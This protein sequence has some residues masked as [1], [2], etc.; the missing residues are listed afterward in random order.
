[1]ADLG[2]LGGADI[3]Y[4]RG[5]VNEGHL[6]HD[7]PLTEDVHDQ[8]RLLTR[9]HDLEASLDDKIDITAIGPPPNQVVARVQHDDP[10]LRDESVPVCG[11]EKRD[12]LHGWDRSAAF[13]HNPESLVRQSAQENPWKQSTL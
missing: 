12:E 13:V 1:M 5:L 3:R 11:G 10:A 2:G 7:A 6:P 4:P 9:I 8:L